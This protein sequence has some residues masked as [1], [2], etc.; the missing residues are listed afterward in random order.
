MKIIIIETLGYLALAIN[1]ISMSAI[2]EYKLRVI[3]TIANVLYIFYGFLINAMPITIGCSIAVALHLYRIR[4]L[5][6]KTK[7]D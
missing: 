1:L 2:G 3:S 5:K 4:K 6:L 7:N